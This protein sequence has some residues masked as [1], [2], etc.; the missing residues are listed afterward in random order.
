MAH[1]QDGD[2]EAFGRLYDRHATT[3]F[4]VARAI[5]RD[6]G[7]AED[8]VQEAFLAI[9]KGRQSYRLGAGSFQAWSM[10]I[11]RN[12]AVDS[13]RAAAIRPRTQAGPADEVRRET[14]SPS[15]SEQVIARNEGDALRA[16]LQDL[17]PAQA[18]VIALAFFAELTHT[19]IAARLDV[20]KGTVKGRM[21]LGLEKLR[22][23]MG[24]QG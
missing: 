9:W 7:Q 24:V 5:C 23:R 10:Q 22:A 1:A 17:P 14:P 8:V 13:A 15:T 20:P 2:T 21:R 4:R 3:A 18:D 12:R 19:E 6:S 16:S 11:V